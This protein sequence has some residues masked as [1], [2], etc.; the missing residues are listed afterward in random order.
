MNRSSNSRIWN[1]ART[2]IAISLSGVP[3]RC[4]ASI[5]SPTT[6]ASSWLSHNPP[7]VGFSPKPASV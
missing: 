6:R 1:D 7:T 3:A 2:R 4:A 5:S